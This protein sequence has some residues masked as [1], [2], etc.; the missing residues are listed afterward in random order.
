MT[1]NPLLKKL[2]YSNKD[3]LV[4]I[5][6]DDVGM[7]H[8]S[9]QGFS[10][11]WEYGTISSGAVMVPCPW[12]RAVAEWAHGHPQVDLGVHGT[13]NSE[14]DGY[15]WGPLSTRDPKSG[16][17]DD[18]G[19][20]HKR[21]PEAQNQANPQA[22]GIEIQLQ[23]QR[24]LEAGIDVTHLDTHMGTITYPKF[25]NGYVQILK[26]AC[27]PGLIPRLNAA[28]LM[29]FGLMGLDE[30]TARLFEGMIRNLEAEGTP[31]VDQVNFMPLDDPAGHVEIARKKLQNLPVGIT[32]LL[33]HPAVDT[34]E[35]RAAAPDWPSRVANYKAF[36]SRELKDFIKNKGIQM[37]GYRQIRDCMRSSNA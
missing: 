6:V 9:L 12:F 25:I 13:V 8:A 21:E 28:A 32:H 30:E 10:D 36:M 33:M 22:V 19:Y 35:L 26:Q 18:E 31:T 27:L 37:I 4:I 24:A 2:G 14:W 34:P 20:F 7:C 29:E 11:L 23:L 5:H 15:R 16:L 3:R 1:P 17:M